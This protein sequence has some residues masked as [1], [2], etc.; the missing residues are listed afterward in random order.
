MSGPDTWWTRTVALFT[1]IGGMLFIAFVVLATCLILGGTE[2]GR[3]LLLSIVTDKNPPWR[4]GL[5]L[6]LGFLGF[7][8]WYWSRWIVVDAY[9]SDRGAWE[10]QWLLEGGPRALGLTPL[11]MVTGMLLALWDSSP[12]AVWLALATLAMVALLFLFTLFRPRPDPDVAPTT[13]RERV[14][15][16]AG[17]AWFRSGVVLALAAL[18]IVLID[19]V[20]PPQAIG[21]AAVVFLSAALLIPVF[22][23]MVRWGARRGWPVLLPLVLAALLFSPFLE[24][25]HTVGRR[26]FG[27]PARFEVGDRPDLKTAYAAWRAQ[28]PA[29]VPPPDPVFIAVEGGASRAGYWTA[30]VLGRLEAET[31]GALS[32]RVFAI[33]AISG[34]NVGALGYVGLLKE[35]PDLEPRALHEKLTDFAG[36]DFLSPALAGMLFPDLLQ[37]VIPIPLLPDR[38]E[39][40]E[41]AWE[42]AWKRHCGRSC[43]DTF[44]ESFLSLWRGG[45]PG[46]RPLVFVGG[47]SQETGRRILTTPVALREGDVDAMDFQATFAKDVAVSTALHNS[48]RFPWISPAGTL[49]PAVCGT[50]R[51]RVER[52]HRLGHIVDG[53]Y[54]DG[55]GV[56]VIRELAEEIVHGVGRNDD[57]QP[58]F[59]F[60]AY[61][62][63][64][65][66]AAR[67]GFEDVPARPSNIA[68]DVVAPI[69]GGLSVRGA[70][71]GH[72]RRALAEEIAD[73]RPPLAGRCYRLLLCKDPETKFKVAMNWALSRRAESYARTALGR[74]PARPDGRDAFSIVDPCGNEGRIADLRERLVGHGGHSRGGFDCGVPPPAPTPQSVARAP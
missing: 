46:W 4:I 29:D 72:L 22:A 54:F 45:S 51:E 25:Q 30:E 5:V 58:I 27:K 14:A 20:A 19:P 6:S 34:G 69:V 67:S 52:A 47:A 41:R 35:R 68:N 7:Q 65:G 18:V 21:P 2:Q 53:G 36:E 70:H 63:K 28:W 62:D 40:L 24:S 55:S 59:I 37:R 66:L 74:T 71:Q 42:R 32:S 33:S 38:A 50:G 57:L 13:L 48:A 23:W 8:A 9:G 49:P 17:A 31:D 16:R 64:T 73:P 61:T 11:L 39:A 3:D 56:E 1:E 10:P 44:R 26:A 60:I 43:P 15:R 12:T